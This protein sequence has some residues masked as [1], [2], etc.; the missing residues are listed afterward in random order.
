MAS[1]YYKEPVRVGSAGKKQALIRYER[2]YRHEKKKSV[3][4]QNQRFV[5]FGAER[6]FIMAAMALVETT[7]IFNESYGDNLSPKH[8]LLIVNIKHFIV[9]NN[10]IMFTAEDLIASNYSIESQLGYFMTKERYMSKLLH[11]LVLLKFL[12]KTG[13]RYVPTTRI[14]LFISKWDS[15]CNELLERQNENAEGSRG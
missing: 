11:D 13:K 2:Q 4:Y 5:R 6:N 14:R 9:D 15:L 10:A 3:Q 7:R 8:A 12:N 1:R